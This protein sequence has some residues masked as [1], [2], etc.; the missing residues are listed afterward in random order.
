MKTLKRLVILV[1]LLVAIVV[2]VIAQARH[3]ETRKVE[4]DAQ[5]TMKDAAD[6]GTR[7]VTE[8][9]TNVVNDLKTGV[10]KAGDVAT[11]MAAK[12]KAETTNAVSEVKEKIN[13]ASH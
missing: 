7:A 5:A 1:L 4:A 3:S 11:N 6:E 9:T 2:V 12:V 10:Q 13:H 8:A